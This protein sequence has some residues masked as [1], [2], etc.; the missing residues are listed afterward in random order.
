MLQL[1]QREAPPPARMLEVGAGGGLFLKAAERAGWDVGGVELS[2]AAVD[3]ARTRLGLDVRNEAAEQ[4]SFAPASFDVAVMFDTIEHLL[5][6][7]AVVR[8]IRT[9]LK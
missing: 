2:T 3:F 7:A 8:A 6:P 5:D 9:A 1:I 4:L